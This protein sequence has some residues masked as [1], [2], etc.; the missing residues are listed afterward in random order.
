LWKRIPASSHKMAGFRNRIEK[1]D[2]DGH[3]EEG[4]QRS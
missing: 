3:I 2:S 4:Q 1:G